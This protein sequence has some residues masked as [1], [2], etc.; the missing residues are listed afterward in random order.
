MTRRRCG[1]GGADPPLGE[2]QRKGSHDQQ[3]HGKGTEHSFRWSHGYTSR[4][5]RWDGGKKLVE[6]SEDLDISPGHLE[7]GP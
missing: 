5:R 4:A 6:G 2:A 1:S 7:T 3:A